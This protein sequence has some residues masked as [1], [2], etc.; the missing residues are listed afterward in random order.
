MAQLEL[1]KV[2]DFP[3]ALPTRRLGERVAADGDVARNEIGN[4]GISA[5][6]QDV[7]ARGL[8]IVVL[9]QIGPA[10]VPAADRL[11]IDAY[12]VDVADRRVDDRR[13][14]AVERHS[15]AQVERV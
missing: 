8:E 3:H 9:D 12:A 11:R 14:G 1:E 13:I 10:T 2:L 5:A 4:G 7:L 15:A 6:E